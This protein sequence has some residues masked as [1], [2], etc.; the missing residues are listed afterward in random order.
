MTT[1]GEAVRWVHFTQC[2]LVQCYQQGI[3]G[4]ECNPGS[5]HVHAAWHQQQRKQYSIQHCIKQSMETWHLRR[6]HAQG[7][8]TGPALVQ[9][10]INSTEAAVHTV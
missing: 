8:I 5:A 9:D 3:S 2:N 6:R 4:G 10:S 1:V 7:C